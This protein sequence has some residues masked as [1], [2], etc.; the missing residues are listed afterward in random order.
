M[1]Q[2]PPAIARRQFLHLG[3]GVSVALATRPAWAGA[4]IDGPHWDRILVLVELKGGN[5]GLNTVI[6]FADPAYRRLR[7]NLGI[8]R[9][10]V[11]QLSPELGLHPA[12]APLTSAWQE[13]DLAV[14][15]G[16]GYPNP[17]RSHF[18]SIE[19]WDTA[20]ASSQTL[21]DG[22][23][24]RAF[25]QNRRPPAMNIDTVVIDDN[26]LPMS[27]NGMR[28]V[29][30]RDAE[31]FIAQARRIKEGGMDRSA[32]PALR[33]VLAVQHEVHQAALTLSERMKAAPEPPVPF[34]QNPFGR[35]LDLASRLLLSKLP[36]TTIKLAL[37]GFDTHARQ[38]E[39][40][41]RL[42]G[43]LGSGLAAF[44]AGLKQAG[45]WDKVLV[46]TYSEFGRR[47]EENGSQGTDHGTAA[48]LF[49]MGGLVKG[50]FH[51]RQPSLTDL[52]EGDLKHNVDFRVVLST[53]LQRWWGLNHDLMPGPND[54]MAFV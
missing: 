17:N 7:P 31:Q 14:L 25:A 1:V 11:V 37:G 12:L 29:V 47:V 23:I 38:R 13:R 4:T 26:T 16:V 40:H 45:L 21:N 10:Q 39:P 34:A 50:G 46:L 51:G 18:R 5:D 54:V 3:L 49:A 48:P 43:V 15:L 24:A 9:E 8:A 35:Q 41:E 6:P 44:R 42:L 20:S 27:G 28:N 36:I 52:S 19:I 22:W 2:P 53:V 32:N 33:H 30:M